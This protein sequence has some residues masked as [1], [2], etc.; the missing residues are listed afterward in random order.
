MRRIVF[1]AV[2]A[3]CLPAGC[4]S[5]AAGAG[6]GNVLG[7]AIGAYGQGAGV[8][9]LSGYEIDAGLREALII[10]TDRVAGELGVRNGYWSDPH[11]RIPLPGRLGD[12]QRELK[13]IGLSAPLDDLQLRMNRAAEDAV[14]AGRE[15]IIDAVRSITIEDAVSLLR[16]G[17]T[18]A[19]DFLRR[20]TEGSLRTTFKP[21]VQSALSSSGA[22][23]SLDSATSSVPMLAAA[24]GDYKSSLTDH[25]VQYGLDGLFDYLAE[26]ETK[27]RENPV[28]RTTALLRKVFG[29]V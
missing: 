25:A 9:G 5:G 18:A 13:R 26:E 16:G 3:C 7:E 22:Y 4:E 27:I 1:G 21:Y 24:A 8:A 28:A 29:A 2:L 19:T 6:F 17:D 20:K 11:I 14:P 23:Q 15:I 12:A 10:G